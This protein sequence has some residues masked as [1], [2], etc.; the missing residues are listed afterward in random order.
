MTTVCVDSGILRDGE[1][2]WGSSFWVIGRWLAVI[3]L[4]H[5]YSPH[6]FRYIQ[7]K[8]ANPCYT[9]GDAD[10]QYFQQGCVKMKG[11]LK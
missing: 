11:K 1:K 9:D 4:V 2:D 6:I 10:P 8:S 5:E 3:T 7:V